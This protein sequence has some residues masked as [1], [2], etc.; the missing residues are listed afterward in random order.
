MPRLRPRKRK[1]GEKIENGLEQS[2]NPRTIGGKDGCNLK[3]SAK[4]K[5]ADS[6][7]PELNG[8]KSS[9]DEESDWEEVESLEPEET[10]QPSTS[11]AS[12]DQKLSIE[13]H[14]GA[15]KS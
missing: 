14:I 13:I 2:K 6:S 8:G 11:A 4:R 7:K 5:E 12:L 10:P 1:S 15:K 9:D 3:K